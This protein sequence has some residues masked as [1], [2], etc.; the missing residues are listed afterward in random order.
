MRILSKKN[1][2]SSCC[3]VSL[4]DWMKVL[5]NSNLY[6]KVS[7]IIF[8]MIQKARVIIEADSVI[9]ANNT[10]ELGNDKGKNQGG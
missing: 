2:Q 10:I 5:N 1:Y 9:R 3:Y 8:K 6:S 4:I 7:K